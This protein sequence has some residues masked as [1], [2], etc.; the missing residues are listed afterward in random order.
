MASYS[1]PYVGLGEARECGTPSTQSGRVACSVTGH[2]VAA[3]HNAD[4]HRKDRRG[5]AAFVSTS[6]DHR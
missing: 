4:C 3:G 2:L 6:C 5:P 1:G